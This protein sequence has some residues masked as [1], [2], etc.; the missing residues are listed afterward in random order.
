MK[1][2]FKAQDFWTE[3]KA[4]VDDIPCNVTDNGDEILFD[5]GDVTLKPSQEAALIKLMAEKPM[6]RGKL[7]KFTEK[8]PDIEIKGR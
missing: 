6:L 8:G 2:R 4:A 5:F 7:A 3:L 1:Y